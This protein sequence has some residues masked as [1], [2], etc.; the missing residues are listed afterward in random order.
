MIQQ[1]DPPA[2]H[3][4]EWISSSAD[5]PTRDP[6]LLA[7]ALR[8]SVL[9][10]GFTIKKSAPRTLLLFQDAIAIDEERVLF[11]NRREI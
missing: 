11:I 9:T 8:P 4:H 6:R 5:V 7:S 2:V 10:M 1:G 3:L